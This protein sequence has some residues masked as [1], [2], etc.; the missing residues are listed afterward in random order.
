MLAHNAR[1]P[2]R[3]WISSAPD[4]VITSEREGGTKA[5]LHREKDASPGTHD[6]EAS[7]E[8]T[9]ATADRPPQSQ[10]PPPIISS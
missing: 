5:A 7:S 9:P 4:L 6:P 3:P 10:A 1:G 2:S 8:D